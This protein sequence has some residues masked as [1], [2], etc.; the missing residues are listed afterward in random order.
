VGTYYDTSFHHQGVLLTET[1]GVW[2]AGHEL[3]Y[4]S[5]ASTSPDPTLQSISCGSPG[6]CSAVGTYATV[7]SNTQALVVS[8][9][10]GTWGL[11]TTPPLPSGG[12]YATLNSVS[13]VSAGNCSAVGTYTDSGG[14]INGLLLLTET[15]GTWGTPPNQ[16]TSQ[17]VVNFVVSCTA[18][19]TC[20]AVGAGYGQALAVHETAGTW[21]TASALSVPP[22]N[23]DFIYS[24]SCG[25]AGN[26]VAVGNVDL[27][28]GSN[29]PMI[30]T[31]TS[32]TWSSG[33]NPT[34]PANGGVASATL[35]Q[36]D[37]FYSVSC[38]SA[39]NCGAVGSYIDNSSYYEGL[40]V[41]QS[42]GTW[43]TGVEA[44]APSGP[45]FGLTLNAVSCPADG[46]C[47]GGG[48]A[49][50]PDYSA[51]VAT[52]AI[53]SGNTWSFMK[54]TLPSNSDTIPNATINAISC[55]TVGNCTA[56][57]SYVD[58]T[59]TTEGLLINETSGVWAT[60]TEAKGAS[61]I[62]VSALSCP[63]AGNCVAI[64]N[65]FTS[66]LL[67]TETAGVWATG[68]VPTLPAGA[69]TELGG[70]YVFSVS[71]GSIGNCSVVG[72]YPN[73]GGYPEGLLINKTS[74][75]WGSGTEA[76]L[77]SG[78]SANPYTDLSSVSCAS[79]GNCSA[80]GNYLDSSNDRQGV[81]LN[82]TSGTWASGIKATP[83]GTSAANPSASPDAISCPT[84]GNCSAIGTFTTSANA[85]A[86]L[87]L[88][89]TGGV[90]ASG[91]AG[92]LPAGVTRNLNALVITCSSFGN[93]VAVGAPFGDGNHNVGVIFT[94]TSGTWATGLNAPLPGN[95]FEDNPEL[96]GVSCTSDGGCVTVGSYEIGSV[97]YP[98][99]GLIET[100][101]SST[102]SGSG[103]MTVDPATITAGSAG[104]TL[105]FTFTA[106]GVVNNGKLEV[107]MPT[108]WSA[109]STTATAAGYTTSTC[110]TVAAS[111]S[112][113]L[114][115]AVTLTGNSTCTIT[116]GST[117]SAGPGATAPA[118]SGTSTFTTSEAATSSG[119]LTALGTSPNLVLVAAGP[120]SPMTSIR[121]CDTRPGNPSN[122][123]GAATQCNGVGNVGTTLAAGSTATINVANSSD[124]G[125]GTFGVP[126]DASAVVM[127]VTATGATGG[128]YLTVFPTGFAQPTA[129]NVNY[130]ANESVP[131]LV[132]VRVGT[133][134]DV[135]IYSSASTNLVI[136]IEGYIAPTTPAGL[137]AGLYQA[138]A[139]PVRI[140][141][142]RPGNYSNLMGQN[143][144]CNGPDN[145]GGTLT[146]GDSLNV[147][148]AGIDNVPVG[149][150]AAVF[151][152]TATNAT[153]PGYLTVY[154]QGATQP[155]AS[156]VN[157][158][159]GRPTSN[160]V[161]VPLSTSGATPGEITI[162]SSKATDVIVDLSGYYTAAGGTGTQFTAEAA[163]VRVC[164]TRPGNVSGLT[165][166]AAQCNG[167]DNSGSTIAGGGTLPIQI[168]GL[169][170]VPRSA[171]AVVVNLTGI[172]PTANTFFTV[173]PN[174]LPTPLVSDLNEITQEVRANMVVATIGSDGKIRIYKQPGGAADVA[175]DVLGWYSSPPTG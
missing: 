53:Q 152:V 129:S 8:Q 26:C 20:G 1:S 50:P 98:N 116:Y 119:T 146:D 172:R 64:A 156:N 87:Y 25:S 96:L 113:I 51:G 4:T 101:P 23:T 137:G 145:E 55:P 77:P 168:V 108:G 170:G 57:G 67:L 61:G 32:G 65:S 106:A 76:T 83:P 167:T 140:C 70:S 114:I 47:V 79:A 127:N 147:K 166:S 124:G 100:Q 22:N 27:T 162:F 19:G 41:T 175:V 34:L 78:A 150:M 125:L 142:T 90:W 122:L 16:T 105:T 91:T 136:D 71:C 17:S 138:L 148:V 92:A 169:A 45:P 154:P 10:S 139:A 103:T 7:A 164:D 104:N 35:D 6:N 84:A 62:A 85:Q 143:E 99:E 13:C 18:P 9:T 102:A 159:A 33:T 30:F 37:R 89:E 120:Y 121:V 56:V 24:I 115:T 111:G 68:V 131:N 149:A 158:V 52:L 110:G 165:G 173:F 118:T 153:Q 14:D 59:D 133:S 86:P 49:G 141:D 95:A 29:L 44:Q 3:T 81:L 60:G 93:C 38:P 12:F 36:D 42:S 174:T 157:L 69:N 31:E 88:T 82:E 109:P 117:A 163:P 171:T 58:N 40:M 97:G 132:E 161:I 123:N 126:A 54:A 107:T 80:V 48:F 15:S 94:E 144:Q 43:A 46:S 155:Y 11:G 128:G 112:N 73:S 74:G 21:S 39:G 28:S 160:R 134:G 5:G 130:V 63:T 135:S 66:G 72:E 2:A 151:N 75:S